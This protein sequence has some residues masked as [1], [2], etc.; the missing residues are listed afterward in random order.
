MITK[1]KVCVAIA[2]AFIA[3]SG[4][5]RADV[6]S[7]TERTDP[8][9][10]NHPIANAQPLL[11]DAGGGVTVNGVLGTDVV[12]AASV[13]DLDF[14]S[15]EGRE[16]DVVT[17]DID[18]GIKS[19]ASGERSVDTVLAVFGA[20][21]GYPVLRQNDDGGLL[22]S[23]PESISSVDSRVLNFRLPASGTYIVGVSSFPR[24]FVNGGGVSRTTLN[25]RSNGRYALVITGV[26]PSIQHI[27]VEIKPGSG[28]L[29]PINPKARGNVPVA[30]LSSAEFD[31]LTVNQE[32]LT[33]GATGKE[34]SLLRCNKEATDVNGDG[35]LDL[36][37]H[38]DNQ[39]ASFDQGDLEG[40]VMGTFGTS[41][42]MFEG[43]AFLKVVGRASK[44]E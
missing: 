17:L 43:R 42:R 33:F 29:A 22:A 18:Y 16:G 8:S 40:I 31:A 2:A 1:R 6:V 27:N 37:C 24:S 14:Y 36:V 38:F 39:A 34:S 5:A 20:G 13:D 3:A 25:T 7:E 11:I 15:F 28:E 21:P 32:S 12:G 19:A 26:T 44:P 30:L 41:K 4:L 10:P 23:D 9:R 35:K